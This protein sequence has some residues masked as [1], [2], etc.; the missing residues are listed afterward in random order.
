MQTS[1]RSKPFDFSS[2]RRGLCY[3]LRL[4]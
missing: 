2:P 4:L 1:S 3:C